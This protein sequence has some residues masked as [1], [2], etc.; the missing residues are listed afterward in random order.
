MED[1]NAILA[2]AETIA[3]A[4]LEQQRIELAEPVTARFLAD[5]HGNTGVELTVKLRDPTRAAAA[6][7]AIARRFGGLARYDAVIVT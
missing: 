5:E 2:S 6:R 4:E 1:G 7:A 3:A